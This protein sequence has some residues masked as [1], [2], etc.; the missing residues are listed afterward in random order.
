MC[1]QG[2]RAISIPKDHHLVSSS[3]KKTN[4]GEV[5]WKLDTICLQ[6]RHWGFPLGL[7]KQTNKQTNKPSTLTKHTPCSYLVANYRMRPLHLTSVKE[8]AERELYWTK[9]QPLSLWKEQPCRALNTRPQ[10]SSAVAEAISLPRKAGV[11]L[12]L[13][14]C[15][16]GIGWPI[17]ANS[18]GR[19][20]F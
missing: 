17:R 18:G 10:R 19:S 5:G 13:S 14:L 8:K 20:G 12:R 1:Y 16:T 6:Q 7:Q 11:R 9:T 15:G 4:Q 3:L 2:L